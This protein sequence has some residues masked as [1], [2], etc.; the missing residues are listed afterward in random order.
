[1]EKLD[2]SQDIKLSCRNVWKIYGDNSDSFFINGSGKIDD[3]QGHTN[4]ILKSDHIVANA[5]VSFDVYAGE[6]FVIM[7]L[8]GSGKSTIVRCLSRLVEPTAGDIILDGENLLEKTPEELI[9]IRR[10]KMGMVFQRKQGWPLGCSA[11]LPV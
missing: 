1:M 11:G 7:G 6:I 3:P 10:H 8:S 4:T 2:G 9:E 5:D